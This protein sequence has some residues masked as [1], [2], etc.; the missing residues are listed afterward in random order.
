MNYVGM[1]AVIS[2]EM[3][4]G[5]DNQGSKYDT[6]D[7]IQNWWTDVDSKEYSARV[8]VMIDQASELVVEGV[9]VR[10]N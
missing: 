7:N 4:R 10:V 8:K 6:N 5:F 3:T 9:D 2:H 1:C